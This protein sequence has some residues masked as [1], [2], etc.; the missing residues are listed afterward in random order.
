MNNS[1]SGHPREGRKV[2]LLLQRSSHPILPGDAQL[3]GLAKPSLALCGLCVR[4][5]WAQLLQARRAKLKPGSE[6]VLP[7]ALVR[8]LE[9]MAVAYKD[10]KHEK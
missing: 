1:F 10:E 7:E 2:L 8:H 6:P 5:G 9:L 3:G 4:Q